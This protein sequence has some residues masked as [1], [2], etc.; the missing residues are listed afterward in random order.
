MIILFIFFRFDAPRIIQLAI[1]AGLLKELMLFVKGFVDTLYLFKSL[2]PE[3]IKNKQK[4]SQGALVS[5]YLDQNDIKDAHNALNDVLMLQKLLEKLCKD[6]SCIYG[7]VK[8]TDS[9]INSKE[10][11]EK[12]KIF[13]RS[14]EDLKVFSNMKYKIAKAGIN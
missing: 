2:L 8:S 1:S 10:I 14:L 6:K 4:F 13:K 7:N 9:I 12:I 11:N 5:D 3:R